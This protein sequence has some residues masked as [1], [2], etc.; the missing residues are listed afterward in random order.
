MIYHKNPGAT[1]NDS[2]LTNEET[3]G[4]T[5]RVTCPQ[6]HSSGWLGE[7]VGLQSPALDHS[8]LLH[9]C[10]F[11]LHQSGTIRKANTGRTLL[12]RT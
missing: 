3:E 10:V 2:Q 7:L 5:S 6:L 11:P 8:V 1:V 12:R 4:Q 9:P